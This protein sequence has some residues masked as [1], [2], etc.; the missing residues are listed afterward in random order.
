[1]PKKGLEATQLCHADYSC[2]VAVTGSNSVGWRGFLSLGTN[3]V[4]DGFLSAWYVF[5][6]LFF[7]GT[8]HR[9]MHYRYSSH[10]THGEPHGN[11]WKPWEPMTSPIRFQGDPWVRV[12]SWRTLIK[13]CLTTEDSGSP[14]ERA[15][16][17]L[18]TEGT[19]GP[20]GGPYLVVTMH[21]IPRTT[22]NRTKNHG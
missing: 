9:S 13:G 20:N 15:H 14:Y 19:M 1:M 18:T 22:V 17:R 11:P 4:S 8:C 12:G 7:C 3:G 6:A 16:E 10:G 2:C 21:K 5:G